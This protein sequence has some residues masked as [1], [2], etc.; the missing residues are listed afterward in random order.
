MN[1]SQV[2]QLLQQ[3]SAFQAAFAGPLS[4]FVSSQSGP[5]ETDK[6]LPIVKT[7]ENVG[8]KRM[9]VPKACSNCRKMHAG[10]DIARPC[11]RCIQNGLEN[12]CMDVPRKKRVSRKRPRDD[13]KLDDAAKIWEHQSS[14]L[15]GRHQPMNI[16]A[17]RNGISSLPHEHVDPIF[18]TGHPNGIR[19][20]SI[21][22]ILP[23]SIPTHEPQSPKFSPALAQQ[24]AE[25]RQ[26]V[27]LNTEN[28]LSSSNNGTLDSKDSKD[29]NIQTDSLLTGWQSFAPQPELAISV[30]QAAEGDDQGPDCPLNVLIDCNEKFVKLVGYPKDVLQKDFYCSKI[31]RKQDMCQENSNDGK[32]AY[33]PKKIQIFTA[34][35]T[36]DVQITVTPVT[37]QNSIPKFFIMHILELPP[38]VN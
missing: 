35:V 5:M 19:H 6:T 8:Q 23:P 13:L 28:K 15:F 36:K 9:Q 27:K 21:V 30:W 10:C 32:V 17:L 14:D 20:P 12:S 26:K 24:L 7:G 16:G 37:D 34:T 18:Q 4:S 3:N 22:P 1:K 29:K 2:L 25:L 31:I 38:T 11:R 33:G